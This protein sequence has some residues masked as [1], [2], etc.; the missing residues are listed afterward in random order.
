MKLF[1][2]MKVLYLIDVVILAVYGIGYLQVKHSLTIDSMTA[3]LEREAG[4]IGHPLFALVSFGIPPL[5]LA[6]Y[7]RH[8]E[9]ASPPN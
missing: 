4:V 9:R 3:V 8:K 2:W 1:D 6:W 7:R 5:A